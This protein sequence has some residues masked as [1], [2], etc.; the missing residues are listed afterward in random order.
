MKHPTKPGQ[1]CR[2]I[3][4]YSLDVDGVAGPN[5]GKVVI[6]VFL[7][8]VQA[9]D[10]VPVWRIRAVDGVTL[11]TSFGGAGQEC[12]ALN[13]WLEVIDDEPQP[14]QSE[15]QQKELDHHA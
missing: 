12:D 4:S 2:L 3:G 10:S 5:H 14:P 1:R 6:T 11:I 15:T 8:Q 13:Y 9:N 7:H